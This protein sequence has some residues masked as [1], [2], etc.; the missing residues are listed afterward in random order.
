MPYSDPAEPSVVKF[1][2]I[3][4]RLLLIDV[5]KVETQVPTTFG[6]SD[7]IRADIAVLDGA[8]KGTEYDDV[9]IFPRVLFRQLERF[10]GGKVVGRLGQGVKKPGQ[11]PPWKL[12]AATDDE[13]ATAA[14]YEAWKA[15]QTP[16][17][18]VADEPDEAEEPF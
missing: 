5:I 14:K 12:T 2:D 4:G 7:A 3:N 10:V 15:A 16:T 13:K 18:T 8:D 6:D 17:P 9:L 11:N 1:D